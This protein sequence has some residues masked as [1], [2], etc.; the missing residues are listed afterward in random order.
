MDSW[1]T[2]N[3]AF[4]GTLVDGIL[5]QVYLV[6]SNPSPNSPWTM[7]STEGPGNLPPESKED[8]EGVNLTSL[9]MLLE[10][11]ADILSWLSSFHHEAPA[12]VR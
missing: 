6:I 12:V 4:T 2:G 1:E 11:G 7:N 5:A 9:K 3:T 8:L 10:R